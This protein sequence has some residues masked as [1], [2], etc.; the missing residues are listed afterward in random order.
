MAVHQYTQAAMNTRTSH[1]VA[2]AMF[3]S[4]A[5]VCTLLAL[6]ASATI[7]RAAISILANL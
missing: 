6:H 3:C 7:L 4:S 2:D 1:S 5:I